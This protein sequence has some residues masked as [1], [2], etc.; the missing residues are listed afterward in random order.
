MI[1]PCSTSIDLNLIN[2]FPLPK[3][4][5]FFNLLALTMAGYPGVFSKEYEK[6]F[7]R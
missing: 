2:S 5:I 6:L 4:I 3:E 7:L 1:F